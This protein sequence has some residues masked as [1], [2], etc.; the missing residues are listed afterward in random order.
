MLVTLFMACDLLIDAVCVWY[1][2]MRRCGGRSV[3][4]EFLGSAGM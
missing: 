3:Q 1:E 2:K 4:S